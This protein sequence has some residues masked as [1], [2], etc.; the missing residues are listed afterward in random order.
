MKKASLVMIVLT[1]VFCA[2]ALGLFLGRSLGRNPVSVS[3]AG[4]TEAPPETYVTKATEPQLVNLNTATVEQ[5][6]ALP[7]IGEVLAKRII[8]YREANGPFE[9]IAQ[10]SNVEGIGDK[11]LENILPYIT[12]GGQ[13]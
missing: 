1:M 9:S 4:V 12:T 3:T 8:A 11:K 7:G 6:T 13:G 5:L 10:L 2:F